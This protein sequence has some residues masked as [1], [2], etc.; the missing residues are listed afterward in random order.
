MTDARFPERWLHD[1]R[2]VRLAPEHFKSFVTSL[3]WAVGNLTD[4]RIEPDDL[5]LI[6]GF[7][8]SSVPVLVAAGVWQ[9]S[10]DGSWLVVD[11]LDTQITRTQMDGLKRKRVLDRD[12]K[13]RQRARERGQDDPRD[14][15]RDGARD[16]KDRTGQDRQQL[17][18]HPERD[19]G[20]DAET[21]LPSSSSSPPSSSSAGPS[22]RCPCGVRLNTFYVQTGR[23]A[24]PG[25]DHLLAGVGTS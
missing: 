10:D 14:V 7:D 22:V 11:F 15:T 6:P 9:G 13:A 21:P 16:T 12:R 8:P 23:R 20:A 17:Q 18:E 1:R 3:V 19:G 25:H 4:G 2:V 24:C 5:P